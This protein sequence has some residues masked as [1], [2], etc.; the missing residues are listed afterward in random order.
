MIVYTENETIC[1]TL[2]GSLRINKFSN[3]AVKYKIQNTEN[4]LYFYTLSMN[5]WT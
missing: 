5:M 1:P 3:F 4:Q 2:N